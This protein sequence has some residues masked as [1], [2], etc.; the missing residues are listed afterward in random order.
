M[1]VN[2]LCKTSN[3][4]G[5]CTSCYPGYSV[6]NGNCGISQL[7]DPN[8]KTQN[9]QACVECYMGFFYSGA[10]GKCKRLNPLCKTSNLSNGFCTSCY[11]GYTVNPSSG[12]C[13]VFFRDPNCKNFDANNYCI[14]CGIRFYIAEGKCKPVNPLC[15]DYN[16][17]N[18]FCTECYSGYVV[19][20]GTCKLGSAVDPNC[21]TLNGDVCVECF[22][23]YF[24]SNGKCQQASPLCKSFNKS[25]GY[26]TSCYPGYEVV[27]A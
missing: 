7:K 20:A 4:Y 6:Q 10:E 13:E 5:E 16:P 21:K 14:E 18:G 26:C 15:K 22:S 1:P 17:S 9:G 8:C 27:G 24:P 12:N 25:N 11:P 2:P 19:S 23:M 3:D